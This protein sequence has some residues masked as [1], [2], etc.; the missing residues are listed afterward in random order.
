MNKYFIIYKHVLN[1][2]K[3]LYVSENEAFLMTNYCNI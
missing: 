2:R 3:H 1:M